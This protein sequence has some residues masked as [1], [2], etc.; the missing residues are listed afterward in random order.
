MAKSLDTSRR[1]TNLPAHQ[2]TIALALGGGGAR[3]LAHILMLEVFDALNLKPV[4]IAGTSIG[5]IFGAAYASGMSAKQIRTHSENILNNRTELARQLLTVRTEPLQKILS[6]FQLRSALFNA[7]ALIDL[8]MPARTAQTF[9]DLQIP[10]H[11]VAADFYSQNEVVLSNGNLRTAISASMALPALFKPV[12]I[13]HM[14]LMDGGLV[15]PLPFDVVAND[16]DI[17][18]AIDVS[19]TGKT[20]EEE[21]KP[22]SA[23]EALIASSQIFQNTI[24][25]EKLRSRQPDILIEVDVG[26]FYVLDFR[27]FDDVLAAAAPAKAELEEKL[28]RVLGAQTLPLI[29]KR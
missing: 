20:A 22:P 13:D 4:A 24:V 26:D 19:G 5:G 18:V 23:F 28:R 2:P 8:I 16:A 3:G 25:R 27:K 17:V 10:L 12:S 11:L 6:V 15:N 21:G 14:A 9:E 7:E 1:K 29:K